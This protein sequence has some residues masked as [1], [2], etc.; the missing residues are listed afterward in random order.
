MSAGATIS[1]ELFML[2]QVN[3]AY[4]PREKKTKTPIKGDPR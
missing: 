4:R 3:M 2:Q 1:H